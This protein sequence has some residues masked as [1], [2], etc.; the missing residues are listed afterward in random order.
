MTFKK[1][2]F[3]VWCLTAED[4]KKAQSSQKKSSKKMKLT[5]K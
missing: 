3:V 2:D 4:A 1:N 5:F